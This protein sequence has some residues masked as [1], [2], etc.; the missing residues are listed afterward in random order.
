MKD[1]RFFDIKVI[2][3]DWY[4]TIS[5]GNF[6]NHLCND[7]RKSL[8]NNINKFL[9]VEADKEL[10]RDWMRGRISYDLILDRV[11]ED[12]GE[13]KDFLKEELI[14]SCETLDVCSK[15]LDLIQKIREGGTKVVLASDNMDIFRKYTVPALK[16]EQYFDDLLLSNELGCLK[17]DL[18][19][20]ADNVEI[21]KEKSS[22]FFGDYVNKNGFGYSQ[23]VLIDDSKC[24]SINENYG[25]NY[26]RVDEA[27]NSR[28]TDYLKLFL[29]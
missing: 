7:G 22:P 10:L 24:N 15:S 19:A 17:S 29:R 11:S 1:E 4:K 18:Y 3:V 14:K 6:W 26:L 2:F 28:T 23:T 27:D 21:K 16:L 8:Y 12:I 5:F 13:S 9:Y 20:D 25:M